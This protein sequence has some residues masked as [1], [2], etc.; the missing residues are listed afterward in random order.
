MVTFVSRKCAVS[1]MPTIS[2]QLPL[3]FKMNW[4]YLLRWDRSPKIDLSLLTFLNLYF[5]I[6][7][8]FSLKITLIWLYAEKN[9]RSTPIH[10]FLEIGNRERVPLPPRRLDI[11]LLNLEQLWNKF[12]LE[13]QKV[14]IYNCMGWWLRNI[15]ESFLKS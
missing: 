6:Q 14:A 11:L 7:F 2:L 4:R 3:S 5:S 12:S 13:V 9:Y 8:F 15:V 10:L 1:S